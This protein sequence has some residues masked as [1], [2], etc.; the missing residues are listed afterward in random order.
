MDI[1]ISTKRSAWRDLSTTLEMT[2]GALEMTDGALEMTRGGFTTSKPF[3]Y[4]HKSKTANNHLKDYSRSLSPTWRRK[5]P[6]RE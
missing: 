6:S 3:D 4:E 2:D 5:V 1:V